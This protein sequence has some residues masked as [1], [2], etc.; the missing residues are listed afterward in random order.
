MAPCSRARVNAARTSAGIVF[1]GVLG[2]VSGAGGGASVAL[3]AGAGAVVGA[4]IGTGVINFGNGI[5]N[6]GFFVRIT[7][8]VVAMYIGTAAKINMPNTNPGNPRNSACA[9][10]RHWVALNILKL[11]SQNNIDHI[12]TA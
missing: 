1:A 8:L 12:I 3:D 9:K 6:S 10:M 7:I 11:N 4:S 2:V 5:L